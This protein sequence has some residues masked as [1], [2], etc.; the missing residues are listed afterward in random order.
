MQLLYFHELCHTNISTLL[1]PYQVSFAHSV[2]VLLKK[3]KSLTLSK[4][5]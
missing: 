3:Y 4:V 1:L 2:T 5:P